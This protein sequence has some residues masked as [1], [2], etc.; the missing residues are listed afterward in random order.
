MEQIPNT[1]TNIS[2]SQVFFL[3]NPK[4]YHSGHKNTSHVPILS[5]KNSV[6]DLTSYF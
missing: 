3:C 1:A 5:R 2:A 6:H 4:L